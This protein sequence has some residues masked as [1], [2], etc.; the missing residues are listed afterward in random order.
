MCGHTNSA[1]QAD[2]IEEG[3]AGNQV[4]ATLTGR[5]DTNLQGGSGVR[6][7]EWGVHLYAG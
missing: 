3:A 6:A 4:P 1:Q 2:G 7:P 5:V